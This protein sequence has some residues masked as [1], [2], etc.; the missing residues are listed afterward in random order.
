MVLE[1]NKSISI[2]VSKQEV[3]KRFSTEEWRGNTYI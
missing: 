1:K 2:V 3:L